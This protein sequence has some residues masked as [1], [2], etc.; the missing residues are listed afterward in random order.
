M[1]DTGWKSPGTVV[2]DDTVG[3]VAWSNPDNAKASDNSYAT[4]LLDNLV[5]IL[6]DYDVKLVKGGTV[7]G[8]NKATGTELTTT[9]TII[10]YGGSSDLWGV[11]LTPTDINSSNFGL[12]FA[13]TEDETNQISNYLKITNCGFDVP[14]GATIN[15]IETH[16][17]QSVS[18]NYLY[19]QVD[20]IQ[21]KVYYTVTPL[22]GE[23]Y[24]LPPFRRLGVI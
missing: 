12:V 24:P 2:S 16:I 9:D 20:H 4:V 21:I 23:K 13:A 22:I 8:N 19:V 5:A 6:T 17:E 3:T 11:S 7:Q 10:S 15:G 14:T 1:S 18:E